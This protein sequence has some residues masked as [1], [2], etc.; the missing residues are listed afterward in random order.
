MQMPPLF[1]I[2][3]PVVQGMPEGGGA[4]Q[5]NLS[6]KKIGLLAEEPPAG[7]GIT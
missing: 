4:E 2:Q 5:F 6:G 3:S 1:Y 7:H